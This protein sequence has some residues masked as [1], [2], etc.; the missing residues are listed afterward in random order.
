LNSKKKKDNNPTLL[1]LSVLNMNLSLFLQLHFAWSF[2]RR[3]CSLLK[4]LYY[5]LS[6]NL[7]YM[8][9]YCTI[10]TSTWLTW[11]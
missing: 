2:I 4:G 1:V 10:Q 8:R 5:G 3:F 11:W 7:Y 6:W 9:R